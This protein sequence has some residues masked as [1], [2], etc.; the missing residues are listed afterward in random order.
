M[1]VKRVPLVSI[2]LIMD[3]S[4]SEAFCMYC[5]TDG[6]DGKLRPYGEGGKPVCFDCAMATPERKKEAE[7]QIHIKME[8]IEP[9]PRTGENS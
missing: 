8:E 9:T 1:N 5:G 6:R 3:A 2:V 4:L 7:R